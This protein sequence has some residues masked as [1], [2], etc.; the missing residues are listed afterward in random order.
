MRCTPT[1]SCTFHSRAELCAFNVITDAPAGRAKLTSFLF[2]SSDNARVMWSLQSI[3]RLAKSIQAPLV[4]IRIIWI[5]N[6]G[7]FQSVFL[8]L[9]EML[10][11]VNFPQKKKRSHNSSCLSRSIKTNKIRIKTKISPWIFPHPS[12]LTRNP[13]SEDEKHPR[14]VTPPPPPHFTVG[15]VLTKDGLWNLNRYSILIFTG[16][17]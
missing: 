11:K 2:Y 8:L 16:L 13:D 7:A 14:S 3:R 12:I 10:L 1:P 9:T 6:A 4:L 5:T 15:M 17:L